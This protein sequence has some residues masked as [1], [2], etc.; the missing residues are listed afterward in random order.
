M[1]DT[2][3]VNKI[4]FHYLS[5]IPW[6]R[7]RLLLKNFTASIFRLE[8]KKLAELQVIFCSDE[9]LLGLNQQY[10]DHSTLT[11][12]I[13]FDLTSQ[14]GSAIEGEIYIS[15]DRVV[16]NAA[17]FGCSAQDEMHRVIFHGVLHLCGYNDKSHGDKRSMRSKEDYYLKSY[18][19]RVPRGTAPRKTR[20]T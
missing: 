17:K 12:I 3:P 6:L 1:A 15:V 9:Y 16:E 2:R 20:S 7:D 10:L 19:K 14:P 8:N 13:T 4:R 18:S 5:R 11:D